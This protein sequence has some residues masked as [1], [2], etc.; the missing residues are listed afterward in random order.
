MGKEKQTKASPKLHTASKM[1]AFSLPDLLI[2]FVKKHFY[3]L[4]AANI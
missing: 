4:H 2:A 1:S 3:S